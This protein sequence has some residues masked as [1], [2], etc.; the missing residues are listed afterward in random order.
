MAK[1]RARGYPRAQERLAKAKAT[2]W[3]DLPGDARPDWP[4][5]GKIVW[6]L[7]LTDYLPNFWEHLFKDDPLDARR[8]QASSSSGYQASAPSGAS[9]P[10]GQASGP[11]GQASAPSGKEL[12]PSPWLGRVPKTSWFRYH[13]IGLHAGL[14]A[15][16]TNSLNKSEE[17]RGRPAPGDKKYPHAEAMSLKDR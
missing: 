2:A 10:A 3:Q 5:P 8:G 17:V 1:V 7:W 13:G 9:G 16:T 4:E 11:A 6:D 12:S 15:V 14:T